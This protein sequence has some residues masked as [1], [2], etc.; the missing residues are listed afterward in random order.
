MQKITITLPDEAK[1]HL[2]SEIA[3][4]RHKTA[5]DYLC[6]LV[7]EDRKRQ[8][9]SRVDKLLLEALNSPVEEV[10]PAFW[11]EMRERIRATAKARGVRE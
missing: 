2:D 8:E 11:Q 6:H 4:G 10:T 7:D 1:E 9:R 5:S 3:S